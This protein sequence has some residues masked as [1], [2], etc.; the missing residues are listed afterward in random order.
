MSKRTIE[1][2]DPTFAARL[3]AWQRKSGRHELPWQRTRDAYRIWLSEIM[4]Q[5][6][7]VSA[8]VGYYG[9]FLDRFPD[10]RAL[11]E[12]PLHEVLEHRAGLGYYARARHL[13]RSAQIVVDEHGEEFPADVNVLARLPGV[14]RSTAAAIAVFAFGRRAAILDGNVKRVLARCFGIE[15]FPGSAA[16]QREL[17]ELAEA[18]LPALDIEAYT[19]GLMDLGAGVCTRAR[20]ACAACPMHAL[21]IARQSGRQAELPAARPKKTRPRRA[22]SMLLLTDGN[23]VLLVRRPPVGIWGGLL[24]LPEVVATD[25]EAFAAQRGLQLLRTS[26]WASLRHAFTHFELD[27]QPL[28][29]DVE[30]AHPSAAEPGSCWLEYAAIESAA[31]PTPIRRLL[32]QLVEETVTEIAASQP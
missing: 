17:W 9:R 26:V 25:A 23:R 16:A 8:V 32:R 29:C 1:P 19:Q 13:H 31:V 30:L 28:R 27:I 20:P 6:T 24:S 2:G 4:L 14:G 11:A 3:V 21:C 10:V 15:G 12:A 22:A 7:Q 18:L 5:Q